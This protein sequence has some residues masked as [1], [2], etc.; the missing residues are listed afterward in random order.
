MTAV[1]E[2]S[3]VSKVYPGP[4]PVRALDDVNVSIASGDLV[5]II[6]PSGAGKSTL[7][8]MMGALDRPT[9]GTIEIDGVD[10]AT[11]TDRRLSGLRSHRIGFVFQDFFLID[12]IS[13]VANVAEGLLYRG[14][15]RSERRRRAID[16]LRR[17]GLGARLDHLPNQLSGGERQRV[18]IARALVGDPAI[19]LADEP[20]GNL[21]SHTSEEIA[22]LFRGLND[23]GTT[24]VVITHDRDL[25]TLFP[26]RVEM[27]DGRLD[28]VAV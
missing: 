22:E 21:D 3:G 1:L 5:A 18:A 9:T 14:L 13:A 25:A 27:R 12:G 23:D 24:I 26:R 15:G 16:S 10:I 11:L 28:E 17:V 19:V 6:G 4:P 2:L 20:T 7:L 8:H